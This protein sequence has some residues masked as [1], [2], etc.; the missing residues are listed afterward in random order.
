MKRVLCLIVFVLAATIVLKKASAGGAS[1]KTPVRGQIADH[2]DRAGQLSIESGDAEIL[3]V[4]W[5]D[6][7][8]AAG[9]PESTSQSINLNST[10][11]YL[12]LDG[13]LTLY[14]F[15]RANLSIYKQG[16][17]F[18]S[19]AMDLLEP[20][21][22]AQSPDLLFGLD[23]SGA[24]RLCSYNVKTGA[25]AV[26]KDFS[27][28][29]GSGHVG[30]LSKA[31]RDD[32]HFSLAWAGPAE[33][34]WR[35]V[36]VWDRRSNALFKFDLNDGSEGLPDYTRSYFDGSGLS[37]VMIGNSVIKWKYSTQESTRLRTD[38]VE[39]S[40]IYAA[41]PYSSYS[42]RWESLLDLVGKGSNNTTQMITSSSFSAVRLLTAAGPSEPGTVATQSGRSP[43]FRHTVSPDGRL[44]IFDATSEGNRPDVFLAVKSQSPQSMESIT[45][46]DLVNC[47]ETGTSLV[48]NAG[49]NGQ[50]DAR[51][52][53]QETMAG[54]GTI[55][56]TAEETGK[57][58]W[59]GF[60]NNPAAYAGVQDIAFGVRL[61][62][63]GKAYVAEAGATKARVK[64]K[65]GDLFAITIEEGNSVDYFK[66]GSLFYTSG[67]QATLPVQIAASLFDQGATIGNGAITPPGG[68]STP[69]GGI[70]W[71]SVVNC[72]TSGAS[73]QKTSGRDDTPDA[74]GISQQAI[75]SGDGYVEFTATETNKERWCGLAVGDMA[76]NPL[77]IAYCWKLTVAGVA[78]VRESGVYKTETTYKTGDRLR[79]AVTGGIIKYYKNSALIYTSTVKPTYPLAVSASFINVGG[80]ITNAVVSTPAPPPPA[81]SISVG[82][83]SASLQPGQTQQ[84]QATVT[85]TAN[86]GVNWSATG[87]TVAASGMYTAPQTSGSYVVRATSAADLTKSAT[88]AVTVAAV[89]T[90]PPIISGI[91]ISGLTSSSATINWATNQASDSTVEYG[92]TPA[93]GST[94]TGNSSLVTNH[95]VGLLSL[96]ASTTYHY[97]VRSRNS[98]GALAVSTDSTFATTQASGGGGGGGTSSVPVTYNAV[99]DRTPRPVPAL[100]ALGGAGSTITDPTFGALIL[101]VTD[102]STR[103][104]RSN[105]AFHSPSSA[106]ANT[107]NTDSTIFYITGEGGEA[108]AYNFD[109]A[110]MKATRMGDPSGP[111]GGAV[112]PF[113]GEPTFSFSNK[114]LL[115]GMDGAT[116]TI[117]QQYDFQSGALTNL[118]DVTAVVSSFTGGYV[119][120]VSNS[121]SDTF[122]IYFGGQAQND[123]TF[124]LIWDKTTHQST[125]LNTQAGT[126]NGSAAG[127]ISWGWTVHNSRIDK[128]GRFVVISTASGPYSLVVWDLQSHTFA[129]IT[130]KGGGHKVGGYGYIVNNDGF[131]DGDQ[132]MIRPLSNVG[133]FS[134]LINPEL[135]PSEWVTD[136]HLSWN[137]AQPNTLVPVFLSTYH[138]QPTSA[139]W[140]AWDDEIVAVRTDGT[141][142]TVWRFAHHFST[143]VDF[144]SSP[145]GNISQDGRFFMFTSNWGNTLGANREDA[146]IVKLPVQ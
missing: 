144:W 66:N 94:A 129:P 90:P 7:A 45:W 10:R 146:F 79:V 11:F 29:L 15:D 1:N 63:N 3:R 81:I 38:S 39:G 85:G 128:S 92:T 68:S 103:P 21:W 13:T 140:R 72:T 18:P 124:V 136:S 112:L 130:N 116:G 65:P 53:S 125:L 34:A 54:P 126:V 88:A 131:T 70:S 110:G 23:G 117:L 83:A 122:N 76:T 55:E 118:L 101:R 115:Y 44:F 16:R 42:G 51:A 17:L 97:R 106:E 111:S 35:Y 98:A 8:D 121:A 60:T 75:N 4:T 86:T 71:T 28:Y 99:T 123:A 12:D 48:K 87:G 132:W 9:V 133:T 37:L 77:G 143:Y 47:V 139:P 62:R 134:E 49:D 145:R 142:T 30:N 61:A 5:G 2:H 104:D 33:S 59:C 78:A 50:D 25:S 137:N 20:S 64:Y 127:S 96:A 107:W 40:P 82:P 36:V 73:L 27:S 89:V 56:F 135:S 67:T 46:T 41:D 26:V 109:T 102:A 80:T 32:D 100:P 113:G 93:Y 14:G 138:S 119:G 6:T 141:Q 24:A 52:F 114:Y 69:G 108:I 91:T 22:S 31:R 84:F 57:E 105:R 43:A 74:G 120:G 95:S 19:E 58:R